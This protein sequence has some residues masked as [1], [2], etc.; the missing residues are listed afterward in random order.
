MKKL[1]RIIIQ[2]LPVWLVV[3]VTVIVAVTG[4]SSIMEREKDQC[5][6]VLENAADNVNEE[7]HIRMEDNGNFLKMTAGSILD[8]GALQDD[9]KLASKL[10]DVQDT[11]IF[12]RID[13]LYP[14]GSALST[15]GT[16]VQTEL[17]FDEIA[18]K[19][20]HM[21]KRRTDPKTGA[22]VI[23]YAVPIE[24]E[25]G[26]Y[27]VLIGV[28]ECSRLSDF[29]Q[30][31]VYDQDTYMCVV[32]RRDGSFVMDNWHGGLGNIDDMKK[33]RLLSGYDKT[34]F[35][36]D[37]VNGK[38][39]RVAFKSEVDK[40]DAY[41]YYMPAENFLWEILVVQKES[42]VFASLRMMRQALFRIGGIGLLMLIGYLLISIH[43]TNQL[44]DNQKET[45]HQLQISTT[46]NACVKELSTYSDID[47]AINNLLEIV[48]RYFGGDRTYLFENDYE[49]Q[50]TKNTY[51]Y[52]AAGVSKEIDNLQAVPLS[53]VQ[54]WM[55]MFRKQGMF[56]ISDRDKE[57]KPGSGT[58]EVLA[59]QDIHSLIAV[60]LMEKGKIYGFLGVD[61]PGKNYNDLS[62]LASIEFYISDS[63]YRK[64]EQE[65]LKRMSFCD[66]PTG[67]YNR[68]KFE[69]V[70]QQ[71]KE[72]RLDHI[73]VAYFDLNGLKETNDHY[74]HKAGDRLI[75]KV[76]DCIDSVFPKQVYRVGGDEFV[77]MKPGVTEN[78][79]YELIRQTIHL[80]GKGHASTSCGALWAENS[81][82]IEQQI[83][84]AEKIMYE[85]KRKYHE[86]KRRKQ[87]EKK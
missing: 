16:R 8:G 78:E 43:K 17:P 49:K 18:A 46:L 31:K 40:E 4:Y 33:S 5:W 12:T 28:L 83:H 42:V 54:F 47:K 14:D 24:D 19:G 62:L 55:D 75:R 85:E 2:L 3:F 60:P 48:N 15:D 50:I 35:Q 6:S 51:E 26:V 72:N 76:T 80:L 61:N 59:A 63:L 56:Y 58:Y 41:M 44:L 79:F 52:A 84:D 67:I 38:T 57:V 13:V 73:G 64:D 25:N 32:D 87:M 20:V 68:N 37:I 10:K 81:G 74:G 23:G 39:G 86:E 27:A 53:Y 71:Y 30:V 69:E 65:K 22:D 7:I 70:L 34:D 9:R 77:V 1:S 82:D 45:E 29:F 21:S 36:S 11:T 66:E